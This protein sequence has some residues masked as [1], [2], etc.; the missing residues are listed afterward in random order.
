MRKVLVI[1][2]GYD[3]HGPETQAA[4]DNGRRLEILDW[5]KDR[6]R[7]LDGLATADLVFVR[8]TKLDGEAIG[9]M[10]AGGGIVRYGVGVDGLDIG[11]ATRRGI[12]IAN[13]PAYGADIE[14][15]D[16]TLS[17]FL[18][19]ARRVCSR[20][21]AVRS[22]VWGLGQAEPIKRIGDRVLG[23]VGYGRIARAVHHRFSAF[24]VTRV[25]VHDPYLSPTDAEAAGVMQVSLAE[26]AS[27]ADIVSLHAPPSVDGPTIDAAFISRMRP[28]AILLNTARGALVDEAA[29]AAALAEGRLFG[30]GLDV[31]QIEPPDRGNLLLQMPNVV[32]SDHTGW[33][34]ESTVQSLQEQA[35]AEA[36]RILSGANPSNWVNPW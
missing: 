8:D 34:S 22:G 19:V 30:A 9:A 27:G 13:I 31:F 18:A 5:G 36:A 6:A 21:L 29:L 26:L 24:G 17:L 33:Y 3:R 35:A 4:A 14:V 1:A 11:A 20:D 12:K 2:P 16:H 28:E 25:L 15:A 10:P 23:M 7:L 32:L